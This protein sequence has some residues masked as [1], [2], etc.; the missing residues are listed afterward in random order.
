MPD[1]IPGIMTSNGVTKKNKSLQLF[2][3]L[4]FSCTLWQKK[5]KK[6]FIQKQ[7]IKIHRYLAK[8]EFVER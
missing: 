3:T 1:S 2:H 6:T 5:F 8:S 7:Y 4:I